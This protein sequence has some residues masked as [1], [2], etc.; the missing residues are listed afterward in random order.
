MSQRIFF[1]KLLLVQYTTQTQTGIQ[2]H[3]NDNVS[4]ECPGGDIDSMD[5]LSVTWYKL[6]S[7]KK[8]GIVRRG[9]D[10]TVT[11]HYT[12]RRTAKFGEKYSLFLPSVTPEDSGDY[13][14]S[15]SANIG[16]QNLNFKV[17]LTVHECL[18]QAEVTTVT[19]VTQSTPPCHK[20]DEELPVMWI[21][22][23]YV[24]VALVKII[25]CLISIWVIRIRSSKR[26]KHRW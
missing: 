24:P 14:C 4:L 1:I 12:F 23:G 10:D 16:G 13:D 7:D 25:S 17:Q 3:C 6:N 20:Q 18:T 21:I 15:I 2:A 9:K 26:R 5:F 19:T 22:I 8:H 11:Q